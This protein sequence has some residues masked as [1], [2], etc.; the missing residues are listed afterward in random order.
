M[1]KI[2]N[3][4]NVLDIVGHCHLEFIEGENPIKTTCYRNRFSEKEEQITCLNTEIQNLLAMCVIEEVDHHPNEY[5]S[6]IYIIPKQ[7]VGEYR[8]I[9]N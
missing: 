5:I 9:L 1:E 8:M 6:P 2:T 7:T 3:D 4:N